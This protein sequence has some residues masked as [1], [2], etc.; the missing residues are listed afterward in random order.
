MFDRKYSATVLATRQEVTLSTVFEYPPIPI[1]SMDWSCVDDDTYD[2][3]FEGSDESGDQW[4]SSPV[5]RGAT[6]QE[7]IQDL[8]EQLS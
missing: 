6:E 7:A 2:A 3:S 5:G 4:K 1:R 8:L